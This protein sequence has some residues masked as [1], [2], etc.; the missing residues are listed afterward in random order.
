[1]QPQHYTIEHRAVLIFAL[2]FQTMAQMLPNKGE[3][4]GYTK[5]QINPTKLKPGALRD[6][7]PG[8]RSGL[9]YSS[10]NSH[11]ATGMPWLHV[12]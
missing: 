12:K 6:I 9:F 7:Q 2:I 11:R 10:Q 4:P 8:N 3:G 5:T 1:M